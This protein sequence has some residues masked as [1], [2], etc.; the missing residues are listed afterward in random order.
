MKFVEIDGCPVPKRLAKRVRR[1]KGK[2]PAA[3]LN[4]CYRGSD[5]NGVAILRANGKR[6]QAELFDCWQ[7]RVPGCNPA[8]PPGRSTHECRSDGAAYAGPLG[9]ALAPWQCGMDW[10]SSEVDALIAGG[11]SFA[12]H[13]FRPYSSGSELHHVNFR[14]KPPWRWAKGRPRDHPRT[15]KVGSRG[16]AVKRLQRSL[17][18]RDWDIE[19]DGIFGPETERV[20]KGFQRK[21]DLEPDGIVGPL[22]WKKLLAPVSRKQES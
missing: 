3:T 1:L 5:P 15:V 16:R 4:S 12:W 17:H 20:V 10:Q 22:T 21:H 11:N 19:L 6:S 8:N 14:V 2:V 9:R 13:L 7:R 18:N